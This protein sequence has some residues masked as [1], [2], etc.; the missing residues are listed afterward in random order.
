MK[1]ATFAR[2]QLQIPF[3]GGYQKLEVKLIIQ[4]A[5]YFLITEC[6]SL[7]FLCINTTSFIPDLVTKI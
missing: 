7:F 1:G 3:I 4:L 5:S 6:G 2:N